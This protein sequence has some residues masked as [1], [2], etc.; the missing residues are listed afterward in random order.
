MQALYLKEHVKNGE[1]DN[2]IIIIFEEGWYYL[3]GTRQNLLNLTST[4][5]QYYFSYDETYVDNMTSFIKFITDNFKT[6][7]TVELYTVD[8]FDE[9]I[10]D[11]D[12]FYF[13][14][15]FHP[16]RL[17]VAYDNININKRYLK[18]VLEFL[19]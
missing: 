18:N 2:N 17:L 13:H 10:H 16:S 9:D 5:E 12:F 14:Q 7:F 19:C 6:R 8:L 3:Y 15:Q 4:H 11:A 1:V